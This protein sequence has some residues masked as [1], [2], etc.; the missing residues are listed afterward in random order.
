MAINAEVN[1]KYEIGRSE[2]L[3][4]KKN[5]PILNRLVDK[6]VSKR[7][8]ENFKL[9]ICLHITKETSVLLMAL[10]QAGAKVTLCPANPLSI[11]EPV[12]FFLI[13]NDIKIFANKEGST[14]D[15]YNNIERV[16]DTKPDI[17]TDDG[18]ELH[19]RALG[20]NFSI[21]GGTEETTS[22]VN[23]IKEL[24]KEGLL[25]YPIIAINRSRTKYLFDNKYGTG[26]STLEG[27]L[28]TTGI[29][30]SSK[31][32]VVCGY[33]WVG[34][35][36]ARCAMGM[37]AKVTITEVNPLRAL[38]AYFDGFDVKTIDEVVSI[39]DVFITCTGQINVI[40][41]HQIEKIKE[42]AILCN[43]GHFDA[44][45]DVDYLNSI[46]PN[47][48]SP[49]MNVSCYRIGESKKKIYLLANGRVINLVGAEGNSSE[50]MSISF[51]NQFLSII[52]LTQFHKKL[53]N[54]IYKTPKKI[55]KKIIWTALDTFGL[56]IDSLTLEQ[57]NYFKK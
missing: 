51:A 28:N 22:G 44:E 50:V 41:Q 29:L 48:F 35:G 5:M 45:I 6:F 24:G 17:L 19:K 25:V 3:W 37:G 52:Y 16:L 55:E 47:H 20:K 11:Q 14:I 36:V 54:R 10:K 18:G 4:A 43:A 42:G 40:G 39:A 21:M 7:S 15:F 53:E 31:R 56:K 23:R 13:K 49:R 9:G 46:D 33:G 34:K 38:E 57:N 26:Q 30:L 12:K 8:L 32:I 27:I 1:E 2:Y